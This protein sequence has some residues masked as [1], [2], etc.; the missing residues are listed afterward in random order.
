MWQ[1][2]LSTRIKN[3]ESDLGYKPDEMNPP[4]EAHLGIERNLFCFDA[5][6]DTIKVKF[7]QTYQEDSKYDLYK[8]C[9]TFLYVMHTNQMLFWYNL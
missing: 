6:S 3:N 2:L 8:T 4:Q 5:L 7:S 1:G 9:Y